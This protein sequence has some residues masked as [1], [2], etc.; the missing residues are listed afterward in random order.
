MKHIRRNDVVMV[1][2]GKDRGKRGKVLK[3]F[4][5][6]LRAIVEGLNLVKK[7]MRP[8]QTNPQGGIITKEAAIHLS[9]LALWCPKCNQPT[10]SGRK[11]LA[12]DTRA[13]FCK[14]CKEII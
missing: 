9:N 7:A 10:R 8:T 5:E 2:C 11:T 12:D 3:V 14:K 4:H 6:N 1:I 13:R